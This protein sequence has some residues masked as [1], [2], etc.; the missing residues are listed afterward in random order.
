LFYPLVF[1]ASPKVESLMPNAS[2]IGYFG[3]NA[4]QYI[5]L[6]FSGGILLG[7]ISSFVAIRRFL[8]I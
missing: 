1:V 6:V 2:L 3:A 8:K 4:L 5:S 7:V